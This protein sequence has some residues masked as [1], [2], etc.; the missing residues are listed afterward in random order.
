MRS[1]FSFKQQNS[2]DSFCLPQRRPHICTVNR[3]RVNPYYSLSGHTIAY[4]CRSLPRVRRHRANSPQGSTTNGY[5]IFMCYPGTNF[6]APLFFRTPIGMWDVLGMC[7][8]ESIEGSY[9]RT[10]IPRAMTT[11]SNRYTSRKIS[12]LLSSSSAACPERH[13]SIFPHSAA[14]SLAICRGDHRVHS[15]GH[16]VFVLEHEL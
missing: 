15:S 5:F 10:R 16:F 3:H 4:R 9:T 8:T 14:I 12:P 7:D 6:F 11:K 2:R 13:I 1:D